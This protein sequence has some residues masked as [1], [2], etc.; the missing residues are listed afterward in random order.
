MKLEKN[1][2]RSIFLDPLTNK[3]TLRNFSFDINVLLRF[4]KKKVI[5]RLKSIKY[6][7]GAAASVW[8]S[9]CQKLTDNDYQVAS[10]RGLM[11]SVGRGRPSTA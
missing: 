8:R 9:A 2:A 4:K 5:F 3:I 7:A 10:S 11:A 6:T 1:Q